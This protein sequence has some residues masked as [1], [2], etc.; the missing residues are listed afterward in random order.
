MKNSKQLIIGI[1]IGIVT[2]IALGALE[3]GANVGRYQVSTGTGLAV[4][5]DTATGQSWTFVHDERH[6][7]PQVDFSVSK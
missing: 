4:I 2:T 6:P 1:L 5:V 7:M 3:K